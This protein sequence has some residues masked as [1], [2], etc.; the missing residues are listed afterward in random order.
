MVK[1]LHLYPVLIQTAFQHF[2]PLSASRFVCLYIFLP[3]APFKEIPCQT[4]S[5]PRLPFLPL[6]PL[7][8][9][10]VSLHIE[11]DIP[12]MDV[13]HAR[14]CVCVCEE[15]I[16]AMEKGM[17]L[18]TVNEQTLDAVL[19]VSSVQRGSWSRNIGKT[20]NPPIQRMSALHL[21][22]KPKPYKLLMVC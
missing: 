14:V 3:S 20:A 7:C 18:C 13:W 6:F 19:L 10:S 12:L 4:H 8:V 21:Q 15:W 9:L 1:N 17:H 22:Y 11:S 16:G 5:V 2:F